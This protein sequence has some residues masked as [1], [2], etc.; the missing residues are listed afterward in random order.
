MCIILLMNYSFILID[1][2][3]NGITSIEKCMLMLPMNN[4]FIRICNVS[5]SLIILKIFDLSLKMI[6]NSLTFWQF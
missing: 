4:F 5:L 1:Y 3:P 6:A 2:L